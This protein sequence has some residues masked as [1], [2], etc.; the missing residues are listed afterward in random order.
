MEYLDGQ[1]SQTVSVQHPANGQHFVKDTVTG[2]IV[3]EGVQLMGCGVITRDGVM[4]EATFIPKR[5]TEFLKHLK[6]LW[7]NVS[8]ACKLVGIS[9][10]TYRN[11]LNADQ[12]FAIMVDEIAED[13]TDQVEAFQSTLA[14]TNK[15]AFMDRAMTLRANRP[16]K[17]D[18]ARKIVVESNSSRI[19]EPTARARMVK[20]KDV[21]DA[22]VVQ[23]GMRN[24]ED[25]R[26]GMVN[27]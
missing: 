19:D 24:Y 17:F 21:I 15:F 12:R 4:S 13:H 27:E 26:K 18:P 23:E 3:V 2:F 6:D 7:P 22:E 9:K 1:Q 5:K 20:L 16:D 8:A 14:K 10:L 25:R 11:H